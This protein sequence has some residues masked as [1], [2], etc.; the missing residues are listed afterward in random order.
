MRRLLPLA[1][2][3]L[4]VPGLRAQEDPRAE[5]LRKI[6]R[7]IEEHSKRMRAE[8]LEGVRG[9]L[10]GQAEAKRPVPAPPPPA[11]PAGAVER[12][13][14]LVTVEL[15]KKHASFLAS[16][17]LEGRAAG[18]PGND[19]ASEYI[20]G[21]FKEAGLKPA[22]DA[23]TYFQKFKVAGRETRNCVGLVEGSDPVLA[24]E[25]VVVGAHY[26]HVGTASQEDFGRLGGRG[27]DKIWNGA[28]DNGSGTT[29]MLAIARAFGSGGI[30]AR[31][32]IVFIA[33]SG[34]E[35][36]LIGSKYYT[37]HPVGTIGQHAFMLN[38]DMVGRN[39]SRPIE[40]HGVG[41]GEG[42]AVRKVV[43]KAVEASGLKA[44]LND[45]VKLVGGDS[46]HSSFRDKKVPYAFF[47]SGFH[48]DYHRPSDHPD[49]LAYDNMVK[50]AHTSIHILLGMGDLEERAKFVAQAGARLKLPDFTD[51][52]APPPRRMGVT[53]QELDD[54]ECD[55]LKLEKAQGGLR[56]DAV[57]A[58]G[59][60]EGAGVKAGDVILAVA[61]VTLPRGGTRDRLR[62]VLT[63]IVK[64]GK[65]VEVVVLRNGDKFGLKATWKD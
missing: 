29:T 56:V 55:A 26:D 45:G 51:P 19:K 15:L 5:L 21:A 40:I 41:S 63:E 2:L 25:Y 3:A 22:G 34:E 38:L 37:N 43:E 9:E 62:Q 32:S 57:Q 14:E 52:S 58:G 16:D 18:Y 24:K 12:A 33:F 50:V 61:G 8:L 60:A 47:F 54:A 59:P 27:E 65:E 4:A 64:P 6:D 23:G 42:G 1:L 17:E 13:K 44:T 30:K 28:D 31:R 11:A 53:V 36:G 35:A 39:P 20:A 7:A 10:R 46:D 48:A 49:K